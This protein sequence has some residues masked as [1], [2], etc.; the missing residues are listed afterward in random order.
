M[1]KDL[2]LSQA[3]AEAAA[4]AQPRSAF[5][6]RNLSTISSERA[7]AR[8]FFR[9]DQFHPHRARSLGHERDFLPR[10]ETILVEQRR[11]RRPHHAQPSAGAERAER[12]GVRRS[13][14]RAADVRRRATASAASSSPG[15][16]K[17]FAAGA[18]I[19]EMQT[20]SLSRRA[21][22]ATGFAC[23]TCC[24]R[25]ASRSSRRCPAMR[26]AAAANW[27]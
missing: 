2:K 27:R 8:R 22:A 18:D 23:G 3:A 25:S 15:R 6:P 20:L 19:K 4:G 1:L 7:A 10:Y 12:A 24:R 16:Q 21:S 14:R 17:A 13:H 11:P 5:T 9:G 26:W